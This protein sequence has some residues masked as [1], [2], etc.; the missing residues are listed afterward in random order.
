MMA[1][2]RCTECGAPTECYRLSESL[3]SFADC[4]AWLC[5]SCAENERY[6]ADYPEN[7]EATKEWKELRGGAEDD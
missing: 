4:P 3:Y 1:D 7:R 5:E 6:R 2:S